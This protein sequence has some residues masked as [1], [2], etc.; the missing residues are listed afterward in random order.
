MPNVWAQHFASSPRS[1]D[2]KRGRH[3]AG[4]EVTIPQIWLSAGVTSRR[5]GA[6]HSLDRR[7]AHRIASYTD[8]CVRD[9][10]CRAVRNYCLSAVL[11]SFVGI[12]KYNNFFVGL[13]GQT[14]RIYIIDIL[15]CG[16]LDYTHSRICANN[17]NLGTF[18]F[19][20]H[21]KKL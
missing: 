9:L 21:L 6:E 8:R 19:S 5:R 12:S 4:S 13:T 7:G 2:P 10:R 16:Y 20:Q 17:F 11:F 1:P 3:L 14:Q 18:L 15:Y